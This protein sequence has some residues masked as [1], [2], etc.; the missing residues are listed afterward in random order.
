M[1]NLDLDTLDCRLREIEQL[2]SDCARLV[3]R[4]Y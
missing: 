2:S 1:V 4:K 3:K